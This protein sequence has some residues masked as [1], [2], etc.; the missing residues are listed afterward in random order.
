MSLI[1]SL[2]YYCPLYHCL[3]VPVEPS[4]TDY[5]KRLD[6][7]DDC[8]KIAQQT[9]YFLYYTDPNYDPELL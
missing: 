7:M 4:V 8:S 1:I 9:V 6:K 3:N 5:Y 2:S